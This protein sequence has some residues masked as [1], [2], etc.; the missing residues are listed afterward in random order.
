M[1]DERWPCCEHCEDCGGDGTL[2]EAAA[3]PGHAG[4]CITC[5]MTGDWPAG[6]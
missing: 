6:G 4:P 1:P 5:Q 2:A 3:R